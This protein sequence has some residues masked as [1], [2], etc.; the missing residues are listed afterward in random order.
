MSADVVTFGETMVLLEAASSGPL[1]YVD[2]FT[3]R[4]GGAESNVAI[5]I[6]KLG[7]QSLWMSKVGEDEFGQFLIQKIRGEG[8]NTDYVQTYQG[9]PTGLYIKEMRRPGDQ[10]VTYYRAGSA[11][12]FFNKEDLN[13]Q[14]IASA[15]VLHITGI[16]PLLSESCSEAVFKA[17]DMAKK[18]NVLVSFDPNL[19]FTLMGRIGEE[20]AK[21][22]MRDIAAKSDLVMPGLDEAEWLYGTND[23]AEIA[24]TLFAEGVSKVVIKNGGEYSFYAE[25]KGEQGRVPSFEIKQIVDAIGAGDGFAAG[26]LAGILEGKS[27]QNAVHFAA[28]VG[29]LVVSSPGDIE[30]LP[31]RAEV[32]AFIEQKEGH[33][34]GVLR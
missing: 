28:A 23:E 33:S 12:S 2:S 6:S 5:G 7:Y 34:G 27:L 13:E 25:A 1:R 3:K 18:H 9:A 16:T 21:Q 31:T 19:R 24:Q 20:K 15:K 4:Y 26:V 30:G 32:D 14:Q 17:I 11:A 29:A 22:L 10:R 8:V